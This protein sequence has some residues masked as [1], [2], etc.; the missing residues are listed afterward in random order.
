VL[1]EKLLNK[2]WEEIYARQK[3][4]NKIF[5][6]SEIIYELGKKVE[7]KNSIYYWAS[8]HKI[9]VF[10]PAITDGALGDNIYFFK[11]NR[12]DF[13]IDSASD[14]VKLNNLAINAEKTGIILLGSG[15]IKHHVC[16]ANMF[17]DGAEYAVYINTEAEY[18]GCDSGALP[19][20]AVSWGKINPKAERIKVFADAT[21]VFP[22]IAVKAFK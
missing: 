10:C 21:I 5:T 11:Y 7:D 15:I 2:F 19:E 14:I 3:K 17:R 13:A 18:N 6:P 4:E 16:N 22:L 9:P 12:K 20:E 8:K 1:L